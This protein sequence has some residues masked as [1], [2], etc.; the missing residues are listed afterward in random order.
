MA[1]FT[2]LWCEGVLVLS[3]DR[4]KIHDA[5]CGLV[6]PFFRYRSDYNARFQEWVTSQPKVIHPHRDATWCDVCL[7]RIVNGRPDNTAAAWA[8][9]NQV[10]RRRYESGESVSALAAELGFS[11]QTIRNKLLK[12]ETVIRRRPRKKGTT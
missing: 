4:R 5:R 2:R 9:A 3:Y 12:A 7:P 11:R 1:P 6:R 10:L 8:E